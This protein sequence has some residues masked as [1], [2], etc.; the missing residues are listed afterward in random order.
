MSAD[1]KMVCLGEIADFQEGYVN[2]K[3][4]IADY[5]DGDVKWLRVVDLNNSF[6]Q[7]TSKTLTQK[8]FQSAGKSAYLFPP[9][10]LAISKSGTIGRVGILKD[11]MCG[12]RAVINI[13]PNHDKVDVRY[14]FYCLIAGRPKIEQLAQ[15]SVQKNLYVSQ[16]SKYEILVPSIYQQKA[17]THILGT[18]DDKIELNKKMNQT[19][20]DIAKAIFKSWFVDFDPVRAKAEG[21]PTGLP[22]E[23]SDLFPDILMDSE[24][25]DIPKGWL[26]TPLSECLVEIESGRRPKGGIDKSLTEGIPSVGAESTAPAGQFDFSKVKYVTAAFAGKMNKGKVQN[27]DVALYKDGGKPGQ[28][29]PRVGIYGDGFPFE[30]FYINEHVF[31]L[32][33]KKLGQPFLYRLISSYG[34]LDQLISKGSVKAAQPGLN[35]G[36][37]I[38]STFVFPTED[39]ISHFNEITLPIL[40]KQFVLGKENE[41]LSELRDTLLPKLISGELRIPDAEKFLEEAGI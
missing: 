11:W 21:R 19:L 34:V 10:S 8:G 28:F 33:S 29:I 17:I 14:V 7:N 37:V 41:V 23:I 39:L 1:S 15:G 25:G 27:F 38:G 24:I 30:N 36:E 2:P 22:P 13:R 4:S 20:E 18:L 3:R 9:E 40:K 26:I 5:F 31:L 35:Q 16:I 12:N 6:V 32:R